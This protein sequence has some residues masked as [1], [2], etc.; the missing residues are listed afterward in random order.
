M[1]ISIK[2]KKQATCLICIMAISKWKSVL[3]FNLKML[4]M[5]QFGSHVVQLD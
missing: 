3:W 4:D 2:S 1:K 5:K